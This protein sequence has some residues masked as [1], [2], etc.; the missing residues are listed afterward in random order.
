MFYNLHIPF[1]SASTS[2]SSAPTNKPSKKAKGS[3]GQPVSAPAATRSTSCFDGVPRDEKE[4]IESAVT[5]SRHLGYSVVAFTQTAT[6]QIPTTGHQ[7]PF[8]DSKVPFGHL[9]PRYST[10]MMDQAGRPVVQLSRLH[11]VMDDASLLGSGPGFTAHNL[12]YLSQYDLLSVQ[13]LSQAA[14][15]HACL[16]LSV[17]GPSQISIITLDFSSL[18]F[19]TRGGAP[20]RL[21]RKPLLQAIRSG[22]VFEILYTPLLPSAGESSEENA[23]RRRTTL[24]LARDLIHTTKGK[25]VIISS[26]GAKWGD[27]RGSGDVVNLGT[28][29]GLAPNQAHDAICATAK[30]VVLKAQ[31]R[32]TF[33]GILS[34]PRVILP[35][36]Q[37]EPVV[38]TGSKRKASDGSMAVEDY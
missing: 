18:P 31:S 4:K 12:P 14:F 27:L 16:N 1:P 35:S 28:I 23:Q 38:D 9:D 19:S 2:S 13:P 29:M 17:P 36:S 30:K 25:G 7:N 11:L 33:K 20:F 24:S 22:V 3:K 37:S 26:G 32:K 21:K 8:A 34:A 15:L 10:N 6:S 5:M